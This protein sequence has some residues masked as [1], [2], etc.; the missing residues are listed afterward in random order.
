MMV[1]LMQTREFMEKY[2]I[3]GLA[4]RAYVRFVYHLLLSREADG[5]GLDSYSDQL[6]TG[7]MTRESVALGLVTS[8]EFATKYSTYLAEN[9]KAVPEAQ[10][11]N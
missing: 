7:V 2:A 3:V 1:Q 6:R 10:A 11:A 5:G 4:D 8:S 9:T